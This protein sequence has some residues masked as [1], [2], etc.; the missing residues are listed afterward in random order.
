MLYDRGCQRTA[1]GPDP[2]PK[3][4]LNLNGIQPADKIDPAREYVIWP[5]RH[6]KNL[7]ENF[8]GKIGYYKRIICYFDSFIRAKICNKSL[9]VCLN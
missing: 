3:P 6:F 7:Y 4:F 8:Y 5:A 1:R 2:A 9:Q